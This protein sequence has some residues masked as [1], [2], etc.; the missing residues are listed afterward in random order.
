MQISKDTYFDQQTVL[1]RL[2]KEIRQHSRL[3]QNEVANLLNKPQSFVSKYETGARRLDILEI[4]QI[5]LVLG[6]SLSKFSDLLDKALE[7]DEK[8]EG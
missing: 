2:L 6:I 5:C 4:R 7:T 8:Y 3:S 1:V